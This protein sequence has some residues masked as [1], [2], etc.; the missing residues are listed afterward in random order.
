MRFYK[1][2]RTFVEDHLIDDDKERLVLCRLMMRPCF[3]IGSNPMVR[4]FL[5]G[6]PQH[7]ADGPPEQHNKG[8][9]TISFY[10]KQSII[11]F[12]KFEDLKSMNLFF[13]AWSRQNSQ[14]S[15]RYVLRTFRPQHSFLWRHGKSSGLE[16]DPRASNFTR[17]YR[18]L[19]AIFK[20]V[21]RW[22]GHGWQVWELTLIFSDWTFHVEITICLGRANQIKVLFKRLGVTFNT[23]EQFKWTPLGVAIGV[24]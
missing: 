15:Q 14:R 1:S 22:T 24:I 4:Q 16:A 17:K 12:S 19:R 21:D 9:R 23:F 2:P 18:K 20:R 11:S 13:F 3:V 5:C 10:W 6:P 7:A 8:K